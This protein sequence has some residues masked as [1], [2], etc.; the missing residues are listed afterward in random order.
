ML[1]C[2]INTFG[3]LQASEVLLFLA[4]A[5]SS[6]LTGALL[7]AKH[8][9]TCDKQDSLHPKSANTELK[10]LVET[11][12]GMRYSWQVDVA[13]INLSLSCIYTHI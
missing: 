7:A 8:C 11:K 1:V 5:G 12:Q 3:S 9:I 13:D 6:W 4:Q 10:C 2:Q